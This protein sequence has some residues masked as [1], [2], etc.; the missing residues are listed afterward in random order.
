MERSFVSLIERG[1]S[2]PSLR[3]LCQIAHRLR[4][5]VMTLLGEAEPLDR[6]L[7]TQNTALVIHDP[8]CSMVFYKTGPTT[9]A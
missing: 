3:V 5:S 4:V 9:P 2:K 1:Q 7:D 8:G 6:M